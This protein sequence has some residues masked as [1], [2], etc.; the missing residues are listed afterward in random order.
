MIE[1]DRPARFTMFVPSD[2]DRTLGSL[3]HAVK[4]EPENRGD[5]HLALHAKM[6]NH[7]QALKTLRSMVTIA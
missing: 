7:I 1:R 2:G 4:R 3:D 6:L 5:Q